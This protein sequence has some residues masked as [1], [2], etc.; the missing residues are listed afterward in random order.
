MAKKK[1]SRITPLCKLFLIL[2]FFFIVLFANGIEDKDNKD[3]D[4]NVIKEIKIQS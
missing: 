4:S 3:R 2:F 1:Q